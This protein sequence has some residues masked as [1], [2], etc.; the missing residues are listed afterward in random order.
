[1]LTLEW[2][3]ITSVLTQKALLA[4]K[5][6]GVPIQ[7]LSLVARA[8]QI[9]CSQRGLLG[10]L[11]SADERRAALARS[12]VSTIVVTAMKIPERVADVESEE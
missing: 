7:K 3:E 11:L 12:G 1:M 5:A 6:Q 9:R 2:L 10:D 4:K 8:L